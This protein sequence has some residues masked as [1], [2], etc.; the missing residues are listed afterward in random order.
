MISF[1]TFSF[2]SV[3]ALLAL[4]LQGCGATRTLKPLGKGNSQADL[5]LGGPMITQGA[6]IPAPYT[7]VGYSYGVTDR[8]NLNASFHPSAALYK[9]FATEFGATTEIVSQ[10]KHGV[11]LVID[12]RFI[13]A[14]NAEDAIILPTITPVLSYEMGSFTPYVGMDA[15]FQI[16]DNDRPYLPQTY[17]PFLGARGQLGSS[18]ILGGEVKWAAANHKIKFSHV[19]H[20][21]WIGDY[22][23]V[24]PYIFVG[25]KF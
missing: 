2:I 7:V 6:P 5:S 13:F 21:S 14:T 22:G 20:P 8:V 19:K 17:A 9:V 24:A 3:G 15:L 18:W 23:Q 16:Q 1:K 12:T 11:E 4:A 25:Y 10:E